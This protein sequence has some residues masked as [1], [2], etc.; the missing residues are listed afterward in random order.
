V[1]FQ[2]TEQSLK[3]RFGY[4]YK[5][6]H[7]AGYLDEYLRCKTLGRESQALSIKNALTRC[8]SITIFI[9]ILYKYF[10]ILRKGN[11][12][13][14]FCLMPKSP[15]LICA[16]KQWAV[17]SEYNFIQESKP[18]SLDSLKEFLLKKKV[19]LRRPYLLGFR[20]IANL[21][22]AFE[23]IE[24]NKEVDGKLLSKINALAKKQESWTKRF[25][26]KNHVKIIILDNDQNAIC[27]GLVRAA[28]SI[29]IQTVVIAHGFIQDPCLV[30]ILP[31][32]ASRLCVWSDKQ[33]ELVLRGMP[34]RSDLLSIFGYPHY[35]SMRFLSVKQDS[36]KVLFVAEILKKEDEFALE[37]MRVVVG[38]LQEGG[39]QVCI[40]LHP[41]QRGDLGISNI[42][43]KGIQNVSSYTIEECLT[44][45]MLV[46]GTNTSLLFEAPLLGIP[47]IQIEEL[48][49]FDFENAVITSYKNIDVYLVKKIID[50]F[51]QESGFVESNLDFRVS[52]L[53][54]DI[55]ACDK[56]SVSCTAG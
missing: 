31:L 22:L 56:R 2:Q 20:M 12:R 9:Y 19:G 15:D 26:K 4:I 29:G 27:Q 5:Y 30:S 49:K 11:A 52:D 25:L 28:N 8:S 54:R 51:D 1:S 36:K 39:L 48:M 55:L 35:E 24:R 13:S 44:Q 43:P 17:D 38:K 37:I 40:R 41:K 46:V 18:N 34:E 53:F 16:L 50:C 3:E 47:S 14:I 32:N 33:K 21:T 10:L 6:P 23:L 7:A 45:S 42:L